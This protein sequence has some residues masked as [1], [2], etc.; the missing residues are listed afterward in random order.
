MSGWRLP[1]PLGSAPAPSAGIFGD[2]STITFA[3]VRPRVFALALAVVDDVPVGVRRDQRAAPGLVIGL[4]RL[5]QESVE[6]VE[7][8]YGL[9]VPLQ[10]YRLSPAADQLSAMKPA[11]RLR[12]R[13]PVNGM[14]LASAQKNDASKAT[15]RHRRWVFDSAMECDAPYSGFVVFVLRRSAVKPG[16][17]LPSSSSWRRPTWPKRTQTT[18]R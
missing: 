12:N 5:V 11:R 15:R 7:F 10:L 18:R 6:I 14:I 16:W 3:R 17:S 9:R 13:T 1:P 8:G 2:R 4:Q